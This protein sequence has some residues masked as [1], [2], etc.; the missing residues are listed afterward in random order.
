MKDWPW[1]TLAYECGHKREVKREGTPDVGE[2]WYCFRCHEKKRIE[3]RIESWRIKCSDCTYSRSYGG[4]RLQ[5]EVKAGR[6]H[7]SKGHEITMYKGAEVWHVWA[8]KITPDF[9]VI[10]PSEGANEMEVPPY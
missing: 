8:T 1:I 6:H 10:L 4:V 3:A 2:K 7:R 5:A 9:T